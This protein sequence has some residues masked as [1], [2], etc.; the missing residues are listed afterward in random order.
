MALRNIDLEPVADKA[1]LRRF[2]ALTRSIY[3]DDPSWVQ[4]LTFER[5][6]HLDSAKNP[7]MR[8]IE[9]F[10]WL[11]YRDG[12]PVG[13]VSAQINRRHLERHQNATGHFG[14]LEAVDDPDVFA[15]LM[16][17]AEQCAARARHGADR[18]ALQSVDQR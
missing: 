13:R 7:F 10:Y 3:A 12:V 4:P 15:A 17:T 2:I 14:F 8:A 1:G 11:A 9:V 6:D 5:L 18:W 16:G